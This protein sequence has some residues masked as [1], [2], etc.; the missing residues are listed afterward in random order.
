MIPI[1]P[2]LY[3]LGAEILVAAVVLGSM[4]ALGHHGGVKAGRATVQQARDRDRAVQAEA[5]AKAIQA[6]REEGGRRV[7]AIQEKIDATQPALEAARAAAGQLPDLD[8]RLRDARAAIGICGR[9]LRSDPAA[10]AGSP[11]ADEAAR[12][13]AQLRRESEAAEAA[14]TRYA[15]EAGAAGERCAAQYRALTP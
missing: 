6:A 10:S 5:A 12:V 9:A 7:A 14:R 11:A 3:K 2:A 8:R 4:F 13:F 1:P 15:D